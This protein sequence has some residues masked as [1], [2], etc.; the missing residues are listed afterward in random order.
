MIKHIWVRIVGD[1]PHTGEEGYIE[2]TDGKVTIQTFGKDKMYQVMLP[3]CP[4]NV[5]SCFA[6]M[7]NLR[8]TRRN[9]CE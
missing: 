1:H 9:H 8:R 3:N 6:S 7:S 5:E 2:S 4:Y